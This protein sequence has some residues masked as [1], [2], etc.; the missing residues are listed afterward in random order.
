M[1]EFAVYKGTDNDYWIPKQSFA[2]SCFCKQRNVIK[3]LFWEKKMSTLEKFWTI[4]K[5]KCD[6]GLVVIIYI[7]IFNSISIN[8]TKLINFLYE[9]GYYWTTC[10]LSDLGLFIY[11]WPTE[12]S[13]IFSDDSVKVRSTKRSTCFWKTSLY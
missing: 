13:R 5:I 2:F 7:Y 12:V 11:R 9:L 6:F 4:Q 10:H 8:I 3:G 1:Q